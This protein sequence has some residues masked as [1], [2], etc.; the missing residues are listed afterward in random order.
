[1]SV[2]R[3]R[4]SHVIQTGPAA[5]HAESTEVLARA[6]RAYLLLWRVK[7]PLH[8]RQHVTEKRNRSKNLLRPGLPGRVVS[9]AWLAGAGVRGRRIESEQRAPAV[10]RQRQRE[11]QHGGPPD[12]L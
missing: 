10:V 6:Y 12:W 5:L 11:W 2:T 9:C 7:A 4:Q 3:R 1:M 8:E